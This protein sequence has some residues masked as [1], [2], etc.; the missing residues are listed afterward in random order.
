MTNI[1]LFNSKNF[2]YKIFWHPDTMGFFLVILWF[3]TGLHYNFKFSWTEL[4]YVKGDHHISNFKK[5]EIN[6]LDKYTKSIL[7]ITSECN[8]KECSQ[9]LWTHFWNNVTKRFETNRKFNEMGTCAL[10]QKLS[11][12]CK[13][14]FPFCQ[15]YIQQ[16]DCNIWGIIHTLYHICIK[17]KFYYFT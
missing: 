5:S 7:W 12:V 16:Y 2:W 14:M 1:I 9:S 3:T 10:I 8:W 4:K 15:N 11:T 13:T 17:F 6:L